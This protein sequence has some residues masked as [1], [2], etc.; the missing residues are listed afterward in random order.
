MENQRTALSLRTS[1]SGGML[2]GMAFAL[3]VV[4]DSPGGGGDREEMALF[5]HQDLCS[6]ARLSVTH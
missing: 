2:K 6:K 1:P 5:A 3:N 4:T